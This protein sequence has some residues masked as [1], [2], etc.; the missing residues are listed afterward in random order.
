MGQ[1]LTVYPEQP[2]LRQTVTLGG[3]QYDLRLVWRDRPA[4]WY[5][6]LWAADG[7]EVWLGQRV[8]PG[9]PLGAGLGPVGKLD[10][11]LLVRG[12]SGGYDRHDLGR[13]VQLVYYPSSELP[14]A[15]AAADAVTATVP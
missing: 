4:A 12:P 2:S 8:T 10:G 5:A 14:E 7:T 11:A 9:W 13:T 15:V 1:I 6:D 3:T